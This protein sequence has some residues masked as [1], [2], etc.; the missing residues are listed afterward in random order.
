MLMA[1]TFALEEQ[2]MCNGKAVYKGAPVTWRE[3]VGLE[4]ATFTAL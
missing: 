4:S 1:A 3:I 2:S